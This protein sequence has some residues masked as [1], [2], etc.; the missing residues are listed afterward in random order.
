MTD[1]IVMLKEISDR[2][3]DGTSLGFKR[4]LFPKIDWR[5]RF[6]CLK[7]AK[8][9]G[10]TTML[11]QFMIETFGLSE[12]VYYL[13]FDHLWFTNHSALDLVDTLHK[14]GITHL[15]IDEVHH[16][17]HWETVVKNIYDFYPDLHVAYSGSSILR[18]NS[19]EGDMSRRQIC[20]DLKG[21]SFREFLSFEGIKDIAP[22]SL[23][24]ILS[25]HREIAAEIVRGIKI[26]GLFAKY[27]EYGY[28]PFYKESPSGYYQRIIEC[29]NKVIESDL[30][31]VEDV[32]PATIRK[33]KRMLAV[34]A[35]SCPQEPNMKALY[36]ELETDRNQ[37]LKMLDVL[38]RAELIS[39]LKTEKDKLKRMSAPEKI[40]CDNVNLMRALVPRADIGTLRETFFVNQLRAAGHTVSSPAKGDFLVDGEWLFEVGGKGKS[41]DQIKD[42][43]K[44]YVAYDDVE[45]GSGNKIPLWLFGFLY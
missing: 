4:Y 24:D 38:E 7:G 15:F 35:E 42:M 27:G 21:L 18:M 1:D 8:G 25:R 32:T 36:R 34:L 40:Y 37:G 20:Y 2:L 33:T 17:E 28:Y 39:L 11:R 19:R 44:S 23:E 9:T 14:N 30:P 45:I 3:I 5:N 16:L 13:S 41:F 26:V 12:S 22:I 31:I 29:I 6:I 10:K 43:P